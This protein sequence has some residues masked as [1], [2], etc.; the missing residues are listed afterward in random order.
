MDWTRCVGTY[1]IYLSAVLHGFTNL[2]YFA[3]DYGLPDL[4]WVATHF[5]QLK[6]WITVHPKFFFPSPPSHW[7]GG[8]GSGCVVLSCWLGL[9]HNTCK[10]REAGF[11][12]TCIAFT[13]HLY[14]TEP[15]GSYPTVVCVCK[16]T[17][18]PPVTD[19]WG[20][21]GEHFCY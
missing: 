19:F 5:F 17:R 7:E 12:H 2:A 14:Q 15:P 3:W 13:I 4:P 6:A 1:V 10:I 18:S 21:Q 20:R 11:L 8:G 9:N 16:P